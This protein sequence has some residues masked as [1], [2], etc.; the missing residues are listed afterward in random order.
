[1][2]LLRDAKVIKEFEGEDTS[3][4]NSP[5]FG[6]EGKDQRQFRCDY[7]YTLEN[8]TKIMIHTETSYDN[9]RFKAKEWD[10]FHIKKNIEVKK[11]NFY[12]N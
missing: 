2:R 5:H 3:A 1:M 7:T 11:H 9:G 4:M 6:Y 10:S 12:G 8:D